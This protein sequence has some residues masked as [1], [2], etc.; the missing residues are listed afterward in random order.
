MS[1]YP[2]EKH[3]LLG[4]TPDTRESKSSIQP[5][6]YCNAKPDSNFAMISFHMTDRIRLIQFSA[7]DISKIN[8]HVTANWPGGI[9]KTR[10]YDE[11][12]ELKLAGNP[13]QEDQDERQCTGWR[14]EAS[15]KR[16][17]QALLSGLWMMG[18]TIEESIVFTKSA[19]RRGRHG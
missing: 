14:K 9:Q 13:W 19:R 7:E 8:N 10:V 11:S 17:V 16:L 1:P 15:P 2:H 4:V 18:W 3:S 6:P 12:Y 5:P